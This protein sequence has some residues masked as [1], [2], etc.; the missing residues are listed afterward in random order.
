MKTA[1]CSALKGG[2]FGS[3]KLK[4]KIPSGF[5]RAAGKGALG[6]WKWLCGV[7]QALFSK[8]FSGRMLP[9]YALLLATVLFAGT[10]LLSLSAAV[11]A[12]TGNRIATVEEIK[13]GE[14]HF[15]LVIVLGCGVNANGEPSHM[16][17]DR[18]K[19]GV[20]LYQNGLCDA[21]LMSGDRREDGSYDEVSVMQRCAVEMGV[22]KEHILIDPR[23]YSTFESIAN[24]AAEH[25]HKRVLIVTQEYHL[26]RSLYLAERLELEAMGVSADLRP[27]TKQFYRD[28]RE[29]LARVKDVY[30]VQR[31][32]TE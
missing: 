31:K 3:L 6:A 1:V 29:V 16:L 22:P 32:M 17:Y 19:T 10:I 28:V 2:A 25:P 4:I 9:V 24:L 18:I 8:V 30:A 11:C 23:G 12:Q 15:D 20:A 13:Q 21:I 7:L 5:F 27:Y 26:Y 14:T